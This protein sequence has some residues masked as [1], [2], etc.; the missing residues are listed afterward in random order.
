MSTIVFVL[1]LA[2]IGAAMVGISFAPDD[3]FSWLGARRRTLLRIFGVVLL[4]WA[5]LWP[6]LAVMLAG[7]QSVAPR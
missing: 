5:A 7:G 6:L 3:V 1:T 4:V 2:L